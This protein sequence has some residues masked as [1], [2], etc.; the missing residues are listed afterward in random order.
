VSVFF[1]EDDKSSLTSFGNEPEFVRRGSLRGGDRRRSKGRHEPL[2]REHHR[3]GTY[4]G[5]RRNSRYGEDMLLIEPA[6]AP[7]RP[8]HL[9]T[10]TL[11]QIGYDREFDAP[12]SPREHR[13][14]EPLRR[15]PPEVFYPGELMRLRDYEKDREAET[16]MRDHDLRLREEEVR[17]QERELD[18]RDSR[19]HGGGRYRDDR[20]RDYRL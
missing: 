10:R 4:D 15:A 16:Y 3:R 17:R 11:P 20:D 8:Q 1:D 9:R 6:R 13:N 14:Y 2:Y 12:L 19:R 18:E 7:R 5:P